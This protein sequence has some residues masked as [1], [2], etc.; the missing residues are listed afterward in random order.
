M[1]ERPPTDAVNDTTERTINN[2][3]SQVETL[4]STIQKLQKKLNAL[5]ATKQETPQSPSGKY[6]WKDGMKWQRTWSPEKK[7]M[8]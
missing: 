4:T 6:T 1:R 8:V 3:A 7:G 5:K 2:L